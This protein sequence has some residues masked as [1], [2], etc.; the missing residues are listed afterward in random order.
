[1]QEDL[2]YQYFANATSKCL[3]KTLLEQNLNFPM[4]LNSNYYQLNNN[5]K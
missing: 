3:T 4:L 1:M 5:K 2:F